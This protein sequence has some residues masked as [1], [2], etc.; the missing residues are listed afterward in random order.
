MSKSSPSLPWIPILVGLSLFLN[1]MTLG[2]FFY[3][4]TMNEAA[5][6]TLASRIE[7][8]DDEI[9]KN[10]VQNYNDT[11]A[12]RQDLSDLYASV[13]ETWASPYSLSH[14]D[15]KISFSYLEPTEV[16]SDPG[17]TNPEFVAN[18]Q[19]AYSIFY[20]INIEDVTITDIGFE[21]TQTLCD[22]YDFGSEA[23]TI[24][25][26]TFCETITDSVDHNVL[27]REATYTLLQNATLYTLTF[28]AKT[29]STCQYDEEVTPECEAKYFTPLETVMETLLSSFRLEVL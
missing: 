10:Y 5:L 15:V 8:H 9:A 28:T 3:A 13:N 19:D 4:Q 20:A 18:Y 22:Y 6:A 12:V 11:Y 27:Q 16:I 1:V 21:N 29:G 14:G 26:N 17:D 25:S 23:V 2:Q 7:T 24:G